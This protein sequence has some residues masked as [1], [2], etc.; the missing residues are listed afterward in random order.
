MVGIVVVSHSR[1][2][3]EGV[4]ELA[5]QMTQGKVAIATAGG[6]DDPDN[7]I[8]TDGIKVMEA[9][10]SVFDESGVLVLMD[11][12]SALLSTEMALEI[13]PPEVAEN[14]TLC[15]AP[16]VEGTMAASVAA[17]T[18]QPMVA[19]VSE[20]ES[21]LMAKCA[22]LGV[23]APATAAQAEA[24]TSGDVPELSS[25]R[26]TI[27]NPHGLHA[28][29]SAALVAEMAPFESQLWLEKGDK[30]V[31]AKSLNAIAALGVVLGDDVALVAAGSDAQ[32]AIDAFM[33]LA[34]N[35]FNEDISAQPEQESAGSES[36]VIA[37]QVEGALTGLSV[38]AGIASGP[39]MHFAN[40]MPDVPEREFTS[41]SDESW[42][43]FQAV[44]AVK[45]QIKA[46]ETEAQSKAGGEHAAIFEAHIMLLTDPELEQAVVEAI[47][48]SVI[49]EQ[50]WLNAVTDLAAV[51]AA[52]ESRY[53]QEREADVWD[54]GRQL[55]LELCGSEAGGPAISEPCILVAHDLSP[56]DTAKLD[57]AMVLGI[58]L[59]GGGKTS[60]SAILARAMGIPALVKVQGLDQLESGTTVTLDGF[61][62]LLWL[63]PDAETR[64]RLDQQRDEWL[65]EAKRQRELAHQPAVTLDGT[66]IDVLANIGGLEDVAGAVQ[67]GAEG[68]GLLRTEFLFQECEILPTEDEQYETYSDIAKALEGRPLTIRSLDVG[69][70]K[71]MPAYPLPEEENPFLGLRGVRLC[72]A[73]VDLF[74]IQLR[75]VLRAASEHP[76]IQLMVPMIANVQELV[77]VKQLIAECR[78][79]L[80][81]PQERYPMKVG[82][83]IEVPSAVLG[84]DVLAKEA[85]FFSIGTNDLT[86]YVMAADRGNPA[87]AELVSY[88]QPALIRALQMT[89]QAAQAAGI[90]VSMCGEMAGDSQVTELLLEMGL[91]KLSASASLIPALKDKVR[92]CAIASVDVVA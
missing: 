32:Q 55:M 92:N 45:Q 53:L 63:T 24:T 79:E 34:D 1:L 3:A 76:S 85:D 43:F 7:P 66:R 57:P 10:E 19:V 71:P 2:L 41:V 4:A 27:Q 89:C 40:A 30:R 80:E 91:T 65:S 75:A 17:M 46:Q 39:V 69:G 72:L 58:C 33:S 52:S 26:W 59:S 83:M 88:Q 84:A 81:L 90:P 9:I 20:A 78:A 8:G 82:I 12:G 49:V 70:D 44:E 22:H 28:R 87:V 62:G 38:C 56:S 73:D 35:H 51:Y 6:I 18:G 25:E 21:A 29:P 15:A 68:V 31:N 64:A 50:A 42:R 36:E 37:E 23:E 13:L 11:M 60:H 47:N 14:V 54:V 77:Q 16:I 67:A 5:A 74:K 61:G 48:T 86:Q